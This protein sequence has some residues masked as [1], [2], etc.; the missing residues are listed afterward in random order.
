[1]KGSGT[2]GFSLIELLVTL[3]VIGILSAVLIPNLLQA[4]ESALD[5]AAQA[6]ARNVYSVA[7]AHLGEHPNN[8]VIAGDCTEGYFTDNYAIETPGS[9]VVA[10]CQ[11]EDPEDRNYPR[12]SVISGP[13]AVFVIPED[14]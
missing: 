11:V 3:A 4:R 7:V 1:M 6:Y 2:S 8:E 14:D 10:S 13:G 9:N 5:R 12:V